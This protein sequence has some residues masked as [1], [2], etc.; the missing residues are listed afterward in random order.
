MSFSYKTLNS[1]D[2]TLT[3]YIANKPWEVK[4]STLSQNGVTIFIG[5]NLPVNRE[6]P[7]D[8][9][10]DIGTSN[11]E[12]RRLVFESIKHLYYENYTSGSLT[13][14]FFQS[15]SYFNYEQTTLV[16]GSMISAFKNLPGKE[17]DGTSI[18]D[19]SSSLYDQNI[20][21]DDRGGIIVVISIDKEVFGSGLTPNSVF[22]SGSDYYLRD[23]GEGNLYNFNNEANY[24]RY[25]SAI[26]D[27]DIYLE[28]LNSNFPQLEYAGNI[29][30]SHGLIVITNPDYLCVF[31]T[32]PTA[33]NNYF[34]YV[35]VVPNF[36]LDILYNDYSDCGILN[37]DSFES[38]G[39]TFPDYTYNNGFL[40]ITPNQSSVIPGIYT[41]GYTISNSSGIRSNT[42]S[43]TLKITSLP[44]WMSN[45]THSS[46]AFGTASII[47]VTFSINYG[48]PYYSYSLDNGS[49]YINSNG[50]FNI[51]IS[52]S[53]TSSDN[54]IIYVK[55]YLGNIVSQSFSSWY[56]G[57]TYTYTIQY[58]PCGPTGTAGEIYIYST[59]AVSASINGGA[60]QALPGFFN[61]ATTSS[62]ILLKNTNNDITSSTLTQT[63]ILPITSSL[64]ISSASGYGEA[65]G[66]FTVYLNNIYP[67]LNPLYSILTGS[68]YLPAFTG[69]EVNSTSYIFSTS[70]LPAG[71][72]TMSAY[73]DGPYNCALQQYLSYITITQPSL[74][75]FTATGSY[76]NSCSNAVILNTTGGVPPYTYFATNINT[77]AVYS[78]NTSSIALDGLNSGSYNL[79]IVD[80]NEFTSPSQNIDIYGR[81][82]IYSGSTCEQTP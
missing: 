49:N 79:F 51:I 56:P 60:Y 77:L 15:S 5:E 39:G 67:G 33:V 19:V 14:Q 26:Y 22:I 48:V 45:V 29:F 32:P 6:Y 2:I 59:T 36:N 13:G 37:F 18:Y 71:I 31:G 16:S 44:L 50:L 68:N 80:N 30:Y 28:L 70:S 1:N 62:T 75:T 57:M 61:N 7:F 20:Y 42:G 10:N 76:I 66:A 58:P 27:K 4:N 53:V 41:L 34:E 21:D 54:N 52:G 63:P 73:L 40:N 55:D 8:P 11:Q 78:S 81:S 35:N 47:P 9:V 24:A 72:Y 69:I 65:N 3:S 38:S 74:I 64:L 43:V 23:D 82:Y 12:Y 46:S 25:N 17:G